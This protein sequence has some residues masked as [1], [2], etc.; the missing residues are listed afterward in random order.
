MREEINFVF[1]RQHRVTSLG[2]IQA[3][4]KVLFNDGTYSEIYIGYGLSLAEAT[5]EAINKHKITGNE[6]IK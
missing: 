1:L 5:Q 2:L 3:K 4:I 6:K